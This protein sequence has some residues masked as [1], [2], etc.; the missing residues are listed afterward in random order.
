MDYVFIIQYTY[1]KTTV[2]RQTLKLYNSGKV[3]FKFYYI[4]YIE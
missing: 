4:Y 2:Y 3:N 1:N